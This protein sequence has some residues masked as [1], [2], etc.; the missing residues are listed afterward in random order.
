M[1]AHQN[2]ALI[3]GGCLPNVFASNSHIERCQ[4]SAADTRALQRA[5]EKEAR[6][7]SHQEEACPVAP[8]DDRKD[9]VGQRLLPALRNDP[10]GK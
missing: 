6:S 8:N 10:K 7:L 9:L 5:S 1:M 2:G 4:L 3:S